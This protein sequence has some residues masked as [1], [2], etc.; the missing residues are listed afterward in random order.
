MTVEIKMVTKEKVKGKLVAANDTG[1][2]V[3]MNL[4][5]QGYQS[6]SPV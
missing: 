2:Q 4:D 1:I 6:D 5:G 3:R